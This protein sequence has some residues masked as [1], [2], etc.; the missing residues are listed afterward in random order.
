MRHS[1][2]NAAL[3][4]WRILKIH[5]GFMSNKRSEEDNTRTTGSAVGGA[6]L[7][8]SLGGPFGAIIGGI[9]GAALGESVND[10]K[11]AEK[12]TTPSND[13]KPEGGDRG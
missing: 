3:V 5:G 4:A 8:A 11:R 10:S 12:K 2:L 6:I 7:G 13:N 1:P 9:V